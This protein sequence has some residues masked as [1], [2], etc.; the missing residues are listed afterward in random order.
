MSARPERDR[1]AGAK[2]SNMRAD[3]HPMGMLLD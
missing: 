1:V 2:L 3:A